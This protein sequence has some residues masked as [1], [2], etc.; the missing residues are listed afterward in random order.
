MDWTGEAE[1]YADGLWRTLRVAESPG[2]RTLAGRIFGPGAIVWSGTGRA[3][4]VESH[5]GKARV[6]VPRASD[7]ATSH[8]QIGHALADWFLV[9][10][11]VPW[12]Q[13]RQL[14]A[15]LA[16]AIILPAG[17]VSDY[18][19]RLGA[20]EI[21][22]LLTLPVASTLLREAEVSRLPT[23]LVVVGRYTRIRGDDAG[24]FPTDATALELLAASRAI[25]VRRYVVP[26]GVV[27]RLT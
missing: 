21:A 19:P 8:W 25:G 5:G 9:R 13:R 7:A 4:T 1:R 15:P 24:R 27:I 3:G 14:R 26:E 23:A 2:A 11:G 16:A 22:R 20:V 18:A 10:D 17:Q 6:V 12:A